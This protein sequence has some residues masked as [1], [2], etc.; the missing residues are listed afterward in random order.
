MIEI[1]GHRFFMTFI[2]CYT[3][4]TW[5]YLMKNKSDVLACFKHFHKTVQTQYGALIKT[6]RSDNKIEYTNKTFE[7]YLSSH[8]IHHQTTCP[9]T[10]IGDCLMYDDLHECSETFVGT[11]SHDSSTID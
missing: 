7:K 2:Y 9:Y 1:D 4:V 10:L 5:L 8:G 6:V 11:S 3:R